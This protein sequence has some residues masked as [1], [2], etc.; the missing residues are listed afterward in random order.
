[1]CALLTA[2]APN[3]QTIL[4]GITSSGTPHLGNYIGAIKPCIERQHDG[5]A[6]YFIADLHSLVKLWEPEKRKQYVLEI[7]ASWLA[8]G[9]DHENAYF[10]LQ[11]DIPEISELCWILMSVTSKGL[12]NR[13]HA[14]KSLVSENDGNDPDK[15]ITMGLFTYPVLM[16]ADILAFNATHVPVGKDQ[17]QHLEIARDIAARFNHLYGETFVLPEVISD[18]NATTIPGLDGRKMSKSYGNTIPLFESPKKLQKLINKIVTNS[19]EPH[20][21]KET[22][23]CSLFDI[24]RNFASES[25]TAEMKERY[26]T[27]IG[28]GEMKKALFEKVNSELEAPRER[29]EQLI[30]HPN[31]VFEILAKGAEKTRVLAKEQLKKV[32]DATGLS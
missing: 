13:S 10:Y 21:P 14:Y 30:A 4:T 15:G 29:Y 28:W 31:E 26:Q 19:L 22:E 17:I 5:R 1:M 27:G 18:E 2:Q 9:F 7:A 23:G 11:S 12:L 8:L 16:T 20:E 6:M 32:K 3:M 25:E 24:Y